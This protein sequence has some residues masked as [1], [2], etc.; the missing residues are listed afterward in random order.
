[1]SRKHLFAIV[2][3]LGAAAIAG[4]LALTRT[5]AAATQVSS[6]RI[7]AKSR[8]LDQLEASLR[9]ALA[10]HPPA[11]P[12]ARSTGSSATRTVYV[13]S[14]AVPPGADERE[15]EHGDDAHEHG[16]ENAHPDGGPDD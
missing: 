10:Q 15:V 13:P 8:A 2:V 5:T 3:L 1:M 16:D 12:D 11:L 6:A 4:L 9:R 14:T 7:A